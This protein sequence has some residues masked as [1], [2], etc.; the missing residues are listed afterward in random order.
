[1]KSRDFLFSWTPMVSGKYN[2]KINVYEAKKEKKNGKLN[3]IESIDELIYVS[4]IQNEVM[5]PVRL[6]LR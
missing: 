3:L 1:M 2:V 5:E 6:L 4:G